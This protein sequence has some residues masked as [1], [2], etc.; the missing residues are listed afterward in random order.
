MDTYADELD[1]VLLDLEMPIMNGYEV[2]KIAQKKEKL[3][4][5]FNISNYSFWTK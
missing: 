1:V 3:R 2:L 4:N 5:I